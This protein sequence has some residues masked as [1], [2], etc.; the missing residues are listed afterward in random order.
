[1]RVID[2]L[3]Q[4]CLHAVGNSGVSDWPRASGG[5]TEDGA[6]GGWRERGGA[7]DSPTRPAHPPCRQ[8]RPS[9]LRRRRVSVLALPRLALSSPDL[10]VNNISE[11]R[12]VLRYAI[13]YGSTERRNQPDAERRVSF[14]TQVTCEQG[15]AQHQGSAVG[16]L[17]GGYARPRDTVCRYCS[18]AC[19][20]LVVSNA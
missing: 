6:L 17:R 15:S 11:L 14:R 4:C 5:H 12:R 9:A 19:V 1:M 18:S 16:L 2:S 20:N 13:L 10:C 3:T 7:H 8:P